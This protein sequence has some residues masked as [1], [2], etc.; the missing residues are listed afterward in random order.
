[1][2]PTAQGKPG[3][4]PNADRA[5]LFGTLLLQF[6][7]HDGPFRARAFEGL[8]ALTFAK[9]RHDDVF[10]KEY[11]RASRDGKVTDAEMQVLVLELCRI[12]DDYGMWDWGQIPEGDA[13]IAGEPEPLVK[14]R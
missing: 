11:A 8:C 1:M 9:W 14:L 4:Y 10:K 12:M 13:T 7:Q 6:Y 2:E 3:A 5:N